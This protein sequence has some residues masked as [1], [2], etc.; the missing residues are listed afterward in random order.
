MYIKTNFGIHSQL[1]NI[2]TKYLEIFIMNLNL[3]NIF[4]INFLEE[5][6]SF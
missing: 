6:N 4:Y 3:P 2:L 5:N 1:K